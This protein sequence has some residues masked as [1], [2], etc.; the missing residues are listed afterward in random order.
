LRRPVLHV[1]V[2]QRVGAIGGADLHVVDLA[3]AQQRDG[4]WAPI[5][6]TP[7]APYDYLDRLRGAGLQLAGM[8]KLPRLT[9][10]CGVGLVHAHGYEAN[11]L[12]AALRG[13]SG[14]WA[15]L[16][17]VVTAHGWIRTT[18]WL[19]LKSELD[20]ACARMADVRISTA[21]AHLAG[22]QFRR[23]SAVVIHNG[24]AEPDAP[25]LARLRSDRR[26]TLS[27]LSLPPSRALVGMVGR[28]SPEKRGDL[29]LAMARQM[30]TGQSDLHFVIVGGGDQRSGLEALATRLGIRQRVTFVGLVQDMT[31][32][33]AVLDVLVQPSD[34][35]GTPR[36]VIEAMA[37][38]V[39]VVATRVGDV[40]D[41]LG[42]GDAGAL[43]SPGDAAA[44]ALRV[45]GLIE[46]PQ[47]ARVQ[48]ERAYS[49]YRDLF[50]V[51]TMH[52]RVAEA[53]AE[54]TR[55]SRVRASR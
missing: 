54:A 6:L 38:R 40:A 2:P 13:M 1:L 35:E 16:P 43:T 46:E 34:T 49:R 53:Y 3:V 5:V 12:V 26:N 19:R 11:Y 36:T 32:M 18:P 41:L 17:M 47:R 22:L 48:A 25:R 45:T 30:A 10:I 31:P 8:R 29:F 55:L 20:R 28:L 42:H 27:Q 44:L 50:T 23:G 14:S 33:Y 37:H 39:P 21:N 7:R 51:G 4:C 24:V 52:R 15:R 9:G